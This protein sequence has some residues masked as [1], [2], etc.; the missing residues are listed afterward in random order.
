M[1]KKIKKFLKDIKNIEM[2]ECLR[3]KDPIP[4][5]FWISVFND[6]Q[7]NLCDV[8][9]DYFYLLGT[10]ATEEASDELEAKGIA[11]LQTKEKYGIWTIYLGIVDDAAWVDELEKKYKQKYPEL[12]FC[13]M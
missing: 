8:C 2:V 9:A 12:S 5:G 4:K 3:C 13:F 10:R 1:N 7:G 11:I 6:K